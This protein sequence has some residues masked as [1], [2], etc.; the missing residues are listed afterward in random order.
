MKPSVLLRLLSLPGLVLPVQAQIQLLN[1][2]KTPD[3]SDTCVAVLNQQ[4]TCRASLAS[5]GDAAGGKP[6]FGIPLFL[7]DAQLGAL[8]ISSCSNSLATWQ[9]RIAGA[10]G[11]TLWNQTNGGKYA[12]AS[13]AQIYI[14]NYNSACLKNR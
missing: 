2:T 8:C 10:C 9:R 11:N 5:I 13:L 14:E 6:P 7:T 1:V 12:M 4:V 3:I